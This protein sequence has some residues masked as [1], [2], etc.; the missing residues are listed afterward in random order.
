MYGDALPCIY[1]K[2]ASDF[3]NNEDVRTA[4]H[5]PTTAPAWTMCAWGDF[6][7][8]IAANGSYWLYPEL[9]SAGLDILF[10]SGDTDGAVPTIGKMFI[11]SLR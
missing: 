7:Y 6:K 9:K 1:D 4:L 2:G 10:F 8:T 11:L 5:I 3:L